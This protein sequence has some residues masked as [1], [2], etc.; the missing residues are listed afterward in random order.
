MEMDA[1]QNACDY[2]GMDRVQRGQCGTKPQSGR[3]QPLGVPSDDKPGSFW[4]VVSLPAQIRVPC[5][6][7][8]MAA[9][10]WAVAVSLHS[11]S[12]RT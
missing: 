10:G 3:H 2:H 11:C 12:K 5:H 1:V 6:L 4:N 7:R 9:M 8:L